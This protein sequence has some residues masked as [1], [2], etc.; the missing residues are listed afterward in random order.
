MNS[1]GSAGPLIASTVA[2]VI[3]GLGWYI[4]SR[5]D[6]NAKDERLRRDQADLLAELLE[7]CVAACDELTGRDAAKAKAILIRLPGHLATILRPALKL[8]HTMHGPL[9]KATVARLR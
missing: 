1:L 9:D 5:R 4:Q 8:K 6:R 2:L 3:A 7:L